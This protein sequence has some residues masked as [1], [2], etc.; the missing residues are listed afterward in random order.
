M[1]KQDGGK[2]DGLEGRG[3]GEDKEKEREEGESWKIEM[4]LKEVKRKKEEKG[5]R[6]GRGDKERGKMNE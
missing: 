3:K 2:K 4:V 6:G 5:W 1:K